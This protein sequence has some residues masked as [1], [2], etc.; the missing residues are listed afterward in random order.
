MNNIEYLYNYL[1]KYYP[2]EQVN[3]I[4]EKYKRKSKLCPGENVG[5]IASQ[6]FG[7]QQTQLNLN[8]FHSVG[9]LTGMIRGIPR[10]TEILNVTE[11]PKLNYTQAPFICKQNRLKYICIKDCLQSD[12]TILNQDTLD[13]Y[14]PFFI[15]LYNIDLQ[16]HTIGLRYKLVTEITGI[17]EIEPY[18]ISK[19]LYMNNII[20][21]WNCEETIFDMWFSEKDFQEGKYEEILNIKIFGISGVVNVELFQV[22]NEHYYYMLDGKWIDIISHYGVVQEYVITNDIW[23]IL[24]WLGIE[25]TYQYILDEM[26]SILEEN[27]LYI[28]P[29]NLELLISI[30]TISGTLT[31]ISRF[32]LKL[33]NNHPLSKATFEESLDTLINACIYHK[34]DPITAVSACILVGKDTKSGTGFFSCLKK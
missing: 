23:S 26:M 34:T 33:D 25:A 14:Y 15:K 8:A 24:E 22:K 21:I 17:Y 32:G 7:E 20:C 29:C 19:I 27:G 31:P 18:E 28:Y 6:A 9:T 2:E 3:E 12:F 10:F 30:M 1:S 13:D 16:N 11:H 5:I 4:I